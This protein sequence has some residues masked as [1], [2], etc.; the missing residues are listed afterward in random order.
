MNHD[1]G[2]HLVTALERTS[3]VNRGKE[4][5]VRRGARKYGH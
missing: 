4:P 1:A 2:R 5:P 3:A